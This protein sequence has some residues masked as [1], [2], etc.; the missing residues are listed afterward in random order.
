MCVCIH[1]CSWASLVL[2]LCVS[3][4]SIISISEIRT[5]AR[6]CTRAAIYALRSSDNIVGET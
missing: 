1:P 3:Y 5:L 6:K 2:I 4:Y